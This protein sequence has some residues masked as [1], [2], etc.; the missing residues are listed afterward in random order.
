MWPL[1]GDDG[2]MGDVRD[3]ESLLM[4]ENRLLREQ[5]GETM[6]RDT[7]D[8]GD[9]AE[10]TGI[11]ESL[12]ELI[13]VKDRALNDSSR[14]MEQKALELES[15]VQELN[16]RA[17]EQENNLAVLRLYQLIFENEPTAILGC[18]REGSLIQFNAAAVRYFGV[19]LHAALLGPVGK[20]KLPDAPDFDF[21]EVFQEALQ[22]RVDLK[23]E[24]Q[25]GKQ[26]VFLRAY[27]LD[28]GMIL[29]GVIL[30]LSELDEGAL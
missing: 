9:G 18:D 13:K 3:H 15:L 21:E 25:C 11:A 4:L 19:G 30:R 2:V 5:L 20:L 28:D 16:Q 17:Q 14:R 8:Q 7:A 1:Q 22:G 6:K 12:F 29:R 26:K 27:R 10:L 24:I 23:H